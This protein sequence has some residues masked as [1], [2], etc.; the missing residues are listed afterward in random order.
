MRW[1]QVAMVVY[2]TLSFAINFVGEK[3]KKRIVAGLIAAVAHTAL[4]LVLLGFGG[5]WG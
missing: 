4:M 2:L 5:F 1:P 3:D